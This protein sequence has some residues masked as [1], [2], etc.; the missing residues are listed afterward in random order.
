LSVPDVDGAEVYYAEL[1]GGRTLDDAVQLGSSTTLA[2]AQGPVGVRSVALD[3][4]NRV[5]ASGMVEDGYVTDLDGRRYKI[6]TTADIE[7]R[8]ADPRPR[9]GHVTFESP[10]PLAQQHFFEPL[11]FK[12]SEGLGANFRWLRCNPIHHTLA[13]ARAAKPGLHHVGI[14]LPDRT[15]LIDACDRLADLGHRVQYGPGRHLVG[16]NIFVYFLDRFGIR[17]ELFCELERIEDPERAPLIR[18][19]VDREK[20]VN[21]W[22][23]QPTDAYWRAV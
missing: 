8:L 5:D 20:S 2:F 7:G 13:F 4:S 3:L 12:A 11:G 16:G 9:L 15:A 18:D 23:P 10:D 21:L 14:E 22:G 6:A 1:L 19:N 17:F